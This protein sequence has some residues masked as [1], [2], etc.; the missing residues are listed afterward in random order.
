MDKCLNLKKY[1]KNIGLDLLYGMFSGAG[2][3][4]KVARLIKQNLL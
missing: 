1:I 4:K 2:G 3:N